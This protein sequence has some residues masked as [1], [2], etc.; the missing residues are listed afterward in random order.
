MT[1][2]NLKEELVY[3]YQQWRTAKGNNEPECFQDIF[4]MVNLSLKQVTP[5][6]HWE[7][8]PNYV[9]ILLRLIVV[10]SSTSAIVEITFL[11]LV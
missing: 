4:Y 9:L 8:N 2:L 10:S 6:K 5:L 11:W 7:I 1:M 3:L